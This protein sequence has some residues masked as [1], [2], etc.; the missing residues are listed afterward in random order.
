MKFGFNFVRYTVLL[1]MRTK[2]IFAN[3]KK[4]YHT[5]ATCT[6]GAVINN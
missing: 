3:P 6:C 4:S 5:V 1:K 2:I